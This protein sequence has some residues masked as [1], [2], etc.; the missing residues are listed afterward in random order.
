MFLLGKKSNLMLSAD[1]ME[2]TKL[3]L[4]IQTI[5]VCIHTH[6]YIFFKSQSV[7]ILLRLER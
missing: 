4:T 1:V 5:C 3:K 6:T 2:V 7:N